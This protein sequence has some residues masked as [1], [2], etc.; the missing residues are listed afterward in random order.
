MARKQKTPYKVVAC[1]DTETTNDNKRHCAFAICY[2][3][4]ILNDWSIPLRLINNDNVK[5]QVT[6]TVY[7]HFTEITHVFDELI[8][9]GMEEDAIPVVMVH[10]LAFEMWIISSYINRFD[11]SA[12]CKSCVKPLTITLMRDGKPVLVFW[13]T[14][15]FYGKSLEVLGDEC[16]YPKLSGCWDYEKYRT[17]DTELTEMEIAYATEDVLVPWAYLG[18]YLNLNVEIDEQDLARKLLTKTSVVR[19]KSIRRCGNYK[20]KGKTTSFMWRRQNKAELPKSEYEMELMHASARGGFTYCARLHASKCFHSGNGMNILKYDANSMHIFHALAHKVPIHYRQA[21]KFRILSAFKRV[22]SLDYRDVLERYDNPFQGAYFFAR[23]KFTNIRLKKGT[24]FSRDGISTLA[25][26]KFNTGNAFLSDLY[27]DNQGG[28]EFNEAIKAKGWR[29][30]A[31]QDADFAFGKFYGASWCILILNELSAWEVAQQFDWD[32]VEVIGEG[33]LTGKSTYATDKSVLSFNEFYKAKDATK[34][35]KELYW[36][37]IDGKQVDWSSVLFPKSFP[38]YLKEKIV[39]ADTSIAKDLDAYYLSVKSELNSLYGC[40]ATNEMK[41]HIIITKDGLESEGYK[42]IEN[43]PDNPKAWYQYGMHIVGWSRIHQLIFMMLADD[44]VDAYICGDTDSH[45]IY[46]MCDD[47]EIQLALEPLHDACAK[48]LWKCSERARKLAEWYPM[49]RLGWYE[50]EGR[51]EAFSA[52]W[53]KSYISLENGR[54]NCVMAGIPCYRKKRNADG[55]ITDKSYGRIADII[56][57]KMGFDAMATLLLGYNVT[58]SSDV[59]LLNARKFPKWGHMD[60]MTGE[61]SAIY[62]Y[63]MC[64]TIGDTKT[65]AN[66]RNSTFARANNGMVCTDSVFIGWDCNADEPAIIKIGDDYFD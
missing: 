16:G 26:S 25:E 9:F 20:F 35:I 48:A 52:S 31:S 38:K 40:E 21:S 2:Q 51:C 59:T 29:D 12:C 13:D 63:P 19:Y 27:D 43:A 42:G 11:A 53:N 62:L 37:S 10:N 6:S 33:Y 15:S 30:I 39:K 65:V 23:F 57:K 4:S 44:I 36:Q 5:D 50:C 64:K 14:L 46:T 58:I 61:P 49:E 24:L 22:V 55:S 3:I 66:K 17:S 47:Y 60:D 41:N 18:Y 34:R 45:K 8:L 54:V 28:M 32:S 56:C 7:R 1:F